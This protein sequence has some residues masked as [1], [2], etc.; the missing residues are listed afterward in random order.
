MTTHTFTR[1]S[2]ANDQ[3]THQAI[4][5]A[6]P[7]IKDC[8][9]TDPGNPIQFERKRR[10]LANRWAMTGAI[11]VANGEITTTIE[12]T[13]DAHALF[14]A[15]IYAALP[16]GL[17]YDHGIGAAT[18]A[19]AKSERFFGSMEL[20]NLV[21]EMTPG[22]AVQM[23]A[24]CNIDGNAGL[25]VLTDRRILA[26]DRKA[27]SASTR[28]IQPKS[29]TSISTGKKLTGETLTLTVSNADVEVTT[30]QHGRGKQ[31]ADRIRKM[32]AV[33]TSSASAPAAPQSQSGGA[34]DE[35]M[36]LAELHAAGVLTDEEFTA[37]KARALDL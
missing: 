23:M 25:I 5:Q 28:E 26:K 36:K 12:G 32:M 20:A 7:T 13:G 37:A 22:E 3:T 35:L 10:M 21:N 19:M 17:L 30:L 2:N 16:D 29:I 6:I 1:T 27:W 4:L 15:E 24:S 31:L 11:T 8:T 34:A 14:V 9:V 33:P 18:A